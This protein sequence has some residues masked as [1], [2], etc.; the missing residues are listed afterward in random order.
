LGWDTINLLVESP[1]Y[2]PIIFLIFLL[3][4]KILATASTIGSGGSGGIVSPSL[5]IGAILGV[6]VGVAIGFD[7]RVM[8]IVGA[9]CLFSTVAHIPITGTLMCGEIFSFE[10]IIPAI[11]VGVIGSW[12]ASQDSIYRT[13]LVSR[14]KPLKVSHKYRIIR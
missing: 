14:R 3:I 13:T 12:I 4:A 1:F 10:F 5:F 11:L 7:P 8:A 6:I 2:F 9:V